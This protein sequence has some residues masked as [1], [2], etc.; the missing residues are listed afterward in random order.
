MVEFLFLGRPDF[1]PRGPKILILKGLGASGRKIGAP[2]KR[3][4]Q[5]RRIQP[6]VLGPLSHNEA[7][8]RCLGARDWNHDPLAIRIAS[9]PGP[10]NG[11]F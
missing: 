9:D 6:P 11:P 3:E 7:G 5:T 10:L 1:Q 4:S 2:Q 8:L